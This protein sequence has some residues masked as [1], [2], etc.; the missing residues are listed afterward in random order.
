[1]KE[2]L[3]ESEKQYKL[4]VKNLP[5]VLYKGYKDWSVEFFDR[6]IESLTGYDVNEF[7]TRKLK[8]FDLVIEEDVEAAKAHFIKDKRYTLDTSKRSNRL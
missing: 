6:K 5:G 2:Q 3:R 4:L 8:W 1:M 7:N